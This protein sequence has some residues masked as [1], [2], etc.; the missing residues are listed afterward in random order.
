MR[1]VRSRCEAD[2]SCQALRYLNGQVRLPFRCHPPPADP[3]FCRNFGMKN[4]S[5]RPAALKSAGKNTFAKRRRTRPKQ[6]KPGNL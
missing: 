2:V 1:A 6:S 4:S 5:T 3:L